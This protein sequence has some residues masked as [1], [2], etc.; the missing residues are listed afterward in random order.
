MRIQLVDGDTRK[1]G[2]R[3]LQQAFDAIRKGSPCLPDPPETLDSMERA[4][5]EEIKAQ[6]DG[7]GL[8]DS[9]DGRFLELA[10]IAVSKA[11][12]KA[13]GEALRTAH[14]F[15]SSLGCGGPISRQRL[16]TEKPQDGEKTLAEMLSGPR[17]RGKSAV[18]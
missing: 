15:L 8:A 6:V 5:Y 10:A 17:E 11:R 1:R 9:S 16:A 4:D 14:A 3:K 2:K 12:R 7:L 18:Q 13:T